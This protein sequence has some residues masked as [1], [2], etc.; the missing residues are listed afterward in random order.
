[1]AVQLPD[2]L[3]SD[4]RRNLT[5]WSVAIEIVR[6][7]YPS[8]PVVLMTAL[9]QS[10]PLSGRSKKGLFDYISKPFNIGGELLAIIPGDVHQLATNRQ[11]T[12][13]GSRW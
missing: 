8:I 13:F 11:A 6:R 1:M 10:R 7:E 3:L 12:S 2:L 5:R 4:I 9:V